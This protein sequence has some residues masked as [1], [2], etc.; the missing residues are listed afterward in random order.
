MLYGLLFALALGVFLFLVARYSKDRGFRGI[1]I[2]LLM[3]AGAVLAGLA[4]LLV[5]Y[6]L[7]G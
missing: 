2:G 3:F 1:A 6:A 5:R 7:Q 4:V